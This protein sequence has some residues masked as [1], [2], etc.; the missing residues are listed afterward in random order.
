MCL[1][2][3][4]GRNTR[5]LILKEIVHDEPNRAVVYYSPEKRNGTGFISFAYLRL[6]ILAGL[7]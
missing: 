3:H 4:A 6:H 2:N 1:M 7:R 5:A